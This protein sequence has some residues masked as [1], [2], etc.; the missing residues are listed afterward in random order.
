MKKERIAIDLGTTNTVVARWNE[1]LDAPEIMHIDSICRNTKREGDVDDSFTVPSC[2]YL[3]A[4]EEVYPFPLK[5]LY[6]RFR[7]KT[8]GLIGRRAVEKDGGLFSPR[9]V[10][11]F[12]SYLGK[13]SYQFIGSLGKWKFTAEDITRIYLR[14]LFDEIRRRKRIRPSRVTFCVPVDFYEF[15]RARLQRLASGMGLEGIRTIDEPVAAA[16]GYGLSI[17]EPRNILVIDFGAGTLDFALIRT[18]EK[19]SEQGKCLVAAKEG[20]PM[21]GNLVD[22]WMVEEI[23]KR[24][25][26]NFDRFSGDPEM[27][28]WYRILLNEACRLKE[29]LFFRTSDTV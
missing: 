19:S 6:R 24:Y 3:Q 13:N 16:L 12:K 20:V 25:A 7:S 1:G 22:A 27:Q 29:A 8:R 18:E 26:Y 11:H 14:E 17:E 5:Y 15:Y 2:V 9:Y 23:A 10:N 28:W 21:G 4:P